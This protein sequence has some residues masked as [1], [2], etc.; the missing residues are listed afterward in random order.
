MF[1][2]ICEIQIYK[3]KKRHEHKM[4]TVWL[5]KINGRRKIEGEVGKI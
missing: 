1:S 4:R 5:G 2:L 3:K